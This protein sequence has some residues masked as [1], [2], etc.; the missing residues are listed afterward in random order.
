MGLVPTLLLMILAASY[1]GTGGNLVVVQWGCENF[2]YR[3][4]FH[5][6]SKT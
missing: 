4:H 5:L 1:I 2:G 6:K 3:F